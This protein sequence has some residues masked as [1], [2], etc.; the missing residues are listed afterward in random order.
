MKILMS[1]NQVILEKDIC[2]HLILVFMAIWSDPDLK[3]E[4][5]SLCSSEFIPKRDSAI[6]DLQRLLSADVIPLNNKVGYHSGSLYYVFKMSFL[7]LIDICV[8]LIANRYFITW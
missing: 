5:K 6:E 7:T 3:Q 4:F 2:D 8:F 1:S